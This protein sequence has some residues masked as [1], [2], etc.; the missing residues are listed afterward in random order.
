MPGNEYCLRG[1]TESSGKVE[2]ESYGA[3]LAQWSV[4]SPFTSEV[5]VSI[6]DGNFLS[7]T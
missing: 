5:A 1:N 4:L 6:P 2:I 3:S 7:V